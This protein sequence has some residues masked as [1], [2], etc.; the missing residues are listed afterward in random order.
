MP[1][2]QLSHRRPVPTVRHSVDRLTGFLRKLLKVTLKLVYL[3]RG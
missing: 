3:L 1:G 2:D